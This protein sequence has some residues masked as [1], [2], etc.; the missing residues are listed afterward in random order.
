MTG[1]EGRRERGRRALRKTSTFDREAAD[2]SNFSNRRR[3]GP[4]VLFPRLLAPH[5]PPP[6]PL[7]LRRAPLLLPQATRHG[8][9]RPLPHTPRRAEADVGPQRLPGPGGGRG[10]GPA[11]GRAAALG[12]RGQGRPGA[13]RG[14][15]LHARAPLLAV[16]HDAA[17]ALRR[18][19]RGNALGRAPRRVRGQLLCRRRRGPDLGV[20]VVG[21]GAQH[22]EP[23]RRP[24]E[25][26]PPRLAAV[27][28]AAQAR[29]R[30]PRGLDELP[31]LR[32]VA[33]DLR[34]AHRGHGPG[35]GTF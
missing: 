7:L 35:F 23:G 13:L 2:Y 18:G 15:A 29:R 5:P 26:R 11:R 12:G 1:K 10:G 21:A 8:H 19:R 3:E 6:L 34:V 25:H 24:L 20:G 28:H 30:D 9:P 14:G 31:L 4:H 16:D 22:L 17:A 32:D 33:I 27:A